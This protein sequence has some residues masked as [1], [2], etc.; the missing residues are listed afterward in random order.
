LK[1]NKKLNKV[2]K[3]CVDEAPGILSFL[4]IKTGLRREILNLPVN[5]LL[6]LS[7]LFLDNLVPIIFFIGVI[8]FEES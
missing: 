3:D 6:S 4:L 2:L 5:L 8:H 1:N 7:K